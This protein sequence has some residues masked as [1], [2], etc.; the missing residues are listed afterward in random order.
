MALTL[1]TN[2][3]FVTVAP[4]ADPDGPDNLIANTRSNALKD[5][6]P[7]T[8]AKVVEI[9]WYSNGTGTDVD[10]D[11][12]LYDHK[13]GDDNPENRLSTTT[14]T[15]GADAGWKKV[16]GLDISITAGVTYWLAFQCDA[17]SKVTDNISTGGTR[18]AIKTSQTSLPDPWG[19]SA[20]E[21]DNHL[22]A[23]YAVWETAPIPL[24][25]T[26]NTSDAF[27]SIS[28]IA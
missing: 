14:T 2:C 22:I 19:T 21:L 17:D 27:T 9:G 12:G 6:A 25:T 10:T 4:T 1:G 3:G 8:S 15:T 16:T 11:I 13:Y 20:A 18:I 5:V 7:A 24:E 26:F 28:Y 23:L